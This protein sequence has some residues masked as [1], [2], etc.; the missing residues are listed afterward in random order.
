[1]HAKLVEL[2]AVKHAALD[3]Y[4]ATVVSQTEAFKHLEESLANTNEF[5]RN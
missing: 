3:L 5:S 2:S 4:N 1:V